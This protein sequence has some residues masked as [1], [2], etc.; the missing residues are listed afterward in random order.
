M[1]NIS[2]LFNNIEV[3]DEKTHLLNSDISNIFNNLDSKDET[4]HKI[5]S[6]ISNVFNNLDSKDETIHTLNATVSNHFINID[7]NG[8]LKENKTPMLYLGITE[9][10]EV[11]LGD[12]C[13]ENVT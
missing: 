8:K 1:A 7:V 5:N 6:D 12:I 9:I 13:I 2:N 11:Y 3:K 10:I 4:I